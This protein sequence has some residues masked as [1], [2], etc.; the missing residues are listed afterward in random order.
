LL[1]AAKVST[2]L[3]AKAGTAVSS[4]A[5]RTAADSAASGFGANGRG[6]RSRRRLLADQLV[7]LSVAGLVVA[8]A[9]PPVAV[10][11]VKAG[12][13][14]YVFSQAAGVA[15][16][17]LASLVSV[18]VRGLLDCPLAATVSAL[19]RLCELPLVDVE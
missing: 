10:I 15:E 5:A 1:F 13:E 7:Q 3:E 19:V 17:M 4:N 11:A 9:E 16:V 12:V 6:P 8:V 2:Q 18:T 14:K